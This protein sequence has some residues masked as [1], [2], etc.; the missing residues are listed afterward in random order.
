M[1]RTSSALRSFG[2][3]T[4]AGMFPARI[5]LGV[6]V[7]FHWKCK[8]AMEISVLDRVY[9]PAEDDCNPQ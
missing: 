8:R 5:C 7:C 2:I 4:R 3:C 6:F 1:S 9:V